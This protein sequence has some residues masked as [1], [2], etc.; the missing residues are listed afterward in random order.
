M[1]GRGGGSRLFGTV[2]EYMKLSILWYGLQVQRARSATK[3]KPVWCGA[4]LASVRPYVS[5][6]LG[7]PER[8]RAEYA[9]I[10]YYNIYN[11]EAHAW[12]C[13]IY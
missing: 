6:M 12:M 8:A 7:R 2:T 11:L 5:K 4:G 10:I 9:Y 1:R 13:N 3:Q